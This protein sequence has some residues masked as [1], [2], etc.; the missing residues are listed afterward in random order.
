M[1]RWNAQANLLEFKK[2][3]VDKLLIL[4]YTNAA[5]ETIQT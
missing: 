5:L 2:Y 4:A 1:V 3:K